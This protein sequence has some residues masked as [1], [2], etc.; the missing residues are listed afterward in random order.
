MNHLFFYDLFAD[1]V[2][3]D[4]I[5]LV[6]EDASVL[7]LAPTRALACPSALNYMTSGH[8]VS[9]FS[10]VSRTFCLMSRLESVA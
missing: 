9:P 2:S 4:E 10:F 1:F 5:V 3:F 6:V 7:A 8:V